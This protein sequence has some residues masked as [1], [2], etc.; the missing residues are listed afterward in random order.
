M[1][2]STAPIPV[3]PFISALA[4]ML[5]SS[6]EWTLT[7]QHGDCVNLI[8][9]NKQRVVKAVC[10]HTQIFKKLQESIMSIVVRIFL[11]ETKAMNAGAGRES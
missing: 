3:I 1:L 8:P 6:R 7:L 2:K 9:A 10:L 11:D 5:G 4:K